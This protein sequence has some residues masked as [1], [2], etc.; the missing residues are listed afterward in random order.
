MYISNNFEKLTG[1]AMV[2]TTD[3]V[4][5]FNRVMEN[6]ILEDMADL[7]DIS[8]IDVSVGTD[9]LQLILSNYGLNGL[10]RIVDIAADTFLLIKFGLEPNIR[11]VQQFAQHW[12]ELVNQRVVTGGTLY[13]K[14]T[15]TFELNGI[16]V[17]MVTRSEIRYQ[18]P[19]GHWLITMFALKRFGIDPTLSNL[20][21]FVPFGFAADWFLKIGD[22]LSYIDSSLFLA[23]GLVE[24]YVHSFSVYVDIN[25][26]PGFEGIGQLTYYRREVSKFLPWGNPQTNNFFDW[27]GGTSVPNAIAAA[28]LWNLL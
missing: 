27:F 14:A 2:S 4:D 5:G 24:Y 20:Y 10:L 21:D 7:L 17:T 9:F 16:P 22:R 15:H 6:S 12:D 3:A 13:G 28:L 25:D 18:I 11:D 8:Y 26:V 19:K 1:A 23:M